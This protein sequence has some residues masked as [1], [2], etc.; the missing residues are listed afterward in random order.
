MTP[1][2]DLS[3]ELWNKF[4]KCLFNTQLGY[5]ISISHLKYTKLDFPPPHT[6]FCNFPHLG[7][8]HYDSSNA[9]SSKSR[10]HLWFF[11]LS[12]TLSN[13]STLFSKYILN[14]TFSHPLWYCDHLSSGQE[15]S[16]LESIVLLFLCLSPYILI[17]HKITM[18][19]QNIK[20]IMS[21]SNLNPSSGT[22]FKTFSIIDKFSVVFLTPTS[23]SSSPITLS[24]LSFFFLNIVINDCIYYFNHSPYRL[25]YILKIN[26]YR[27]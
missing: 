19:F 21:I 6:C 23:L 24:L 9:L 14:P 10:S 2:F 15:N 4:P 16:L 3:L 26:K 11:S 27:G 12:H 18:I 17:L 5:L 22:S 20:Q 8:W 7:K 13:L 1:R 25:I